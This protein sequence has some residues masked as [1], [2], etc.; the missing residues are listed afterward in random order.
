MLVTI[1]LFARLRELAGESEM[2]HDLPPDATVRTAWEATVRR[3]PSLADHERSLSAAVNADYAHFTTRLQEGD[4]VAFLP[5][6]S[7]GQDRR[8]KTRRQKAGGASGSSR[9]R[10]TTLDWRRALDWRLT[11]D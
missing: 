5:P 8:Q 4:E 11:L 2:R 10:R 6:V 7:G 3:F 1:L 9:P